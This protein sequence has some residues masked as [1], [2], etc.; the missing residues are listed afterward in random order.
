MNLDYVNYVKS[1]LREKINKLSAKSVINL[2]NK[3][4][5]SSV[6]IAKQN[7]K[8]NLKTYVIIAAK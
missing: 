4:L 5:I 7:S 1:R 3:I 2:S 8:R 6:L